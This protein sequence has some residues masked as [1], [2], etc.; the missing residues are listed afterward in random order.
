MSMR[1][2][3]TIHLKVKALR[4]TSQVPKRSALNEILHVSGPPGE[5]DL[6]RLRIP[7]VGIHVVS[8]LLALGGIHQAYSGTKL[9]IHYSNHACNVLRTETLDMI[10]V[11]W[12]TM[13]SLS[14][15]SG[16]PESV[17][18]ESS[19]FVLGYYM[20]SVHVNRFSGFWITLIPC[21]LHLSYIHV[22][23]H[24]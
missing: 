3:A 13:Q 1:L 12:M 23:V 8:Y 22:H 10:L 15:W 11:G 18:R 17:A 21:P 6:H 4:S 2:Y 24:V 19:C 14:K 16:I 9:C 5:G 7:F 20:Y